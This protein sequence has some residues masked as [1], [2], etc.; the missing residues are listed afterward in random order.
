MPVDR[1]EQGDNAGERVNALADRIRSGETLDAGTLDRLSR[2]EPDLSRAVARRAIQAATPEEMQ[3]ACRDF[4]TTVWL[5]GQSHLSSAEQVAGPPRLPSDNT[6]DN[7]RVI[8]DELYR[9]AGS[10][11]AYTKLDAAITWPGEKKS[12]K[13]PGEAL[14]LYNSMGQ[15]E[16]TLTRQPL[17]LDDILGAHPAS[18]RDPEKVRAKANE[19]H[20]E[21]FTMTHDDNDETGSCTGTNEYYAVTAGKPVTHDLGMDGPLGVALYHKDKPQAVAAFEYRPG[22]MCTRVAP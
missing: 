11:H 10:D 3:Q 13:P 14:T 8:E 17:P 20:V 2:D 4:R 15:L 19:Y 9:H 1:G 18:G 16:R 6:S 5:R 12:A 22:A 7:I 21:P